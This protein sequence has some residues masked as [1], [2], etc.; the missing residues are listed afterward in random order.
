[1]AKKQ[2]KELG[3]RNMSTGTRIIVGIFAVV[4]ALSMMLPSLAPIFA[5][6][7]AS[8]QAEQE[9]DG[10]NETETETTTEEEATSED[11][12][13]APDASL[14]EAIANVPDNESLKSLAEQYE[15]SNAK[16]LKRLEDD[17]N[18]LAALLN[19]AQNYMDWGYSAVHSSS[20]DE[21]TSYSQ[22]LL[23]KAMEYYDRYLKLHDSDAAKVQRVLCQYYAGKTDEAVAALKA[24]TEEKPDYPLA[25]ANLGM[26]YE[27]QYDY[28][29]AL[30]AYGKAKETD[31]DDDY[32]VKNYAEQ[33]INAINASRANFSNLTNE[34]LLGTDSKP[35]EG[36]A[37]VIANNSG[38]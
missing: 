32:G 11:E 15:K 4:M 34:E 7:S 28:D 37:G 6:E 27:Q 10:T 13:A 14:D 9:D 8:Q 21:E 16:F 38:I 29:E 22:A 24:I 19:L 17:P 23:N 20:T 18:D 26:L 31:P 5:S 30:E 36:F 35:Q 1:M 12:Q 2:Q 25:W 33:R 3:G